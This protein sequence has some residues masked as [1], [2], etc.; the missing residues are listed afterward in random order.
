MRG[1]G[2]MAER[3]GENEKRDEAAGVK[4]RGG[5]FFKEHRIISPA[6]YMTASLKCSRCCYS[7]FLPNLKTLFIQV[8]VFNY[9][10]AYKLF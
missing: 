7:A 6:V 5:G 2:E 9:L 8:E 10:P 3:E 4:S 1:N